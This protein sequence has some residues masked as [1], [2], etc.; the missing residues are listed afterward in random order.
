M[1]TRSSCL[2]LKQVLCLLFTSFAW[3]FVFDYYEIT[4]ERRTKSFPPGAFSSLCYDALFWL[5]LFFYCL[6]WFIFTI[7]YKL[8]CRIEKEAGENWLFFTCSHTSFSLQLICFLLFLRR[9]FFLDLLYLQLM[10]CA[11]L[12]GDLRRR[13]S[14][15]LNLKLFTIHYAM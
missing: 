2:T 5:W 15:L 4:D 13:C 11:T 7:I 8:I 6:D 14:S 12:E 1:T 10:H 3:E 9:M